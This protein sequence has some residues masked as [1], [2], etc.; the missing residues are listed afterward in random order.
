MKRNT[1]HDPASQNGSPPASRWIWLLIIAC[2]LVIFIALRRAAR[3]HEMVSTEASTDPPRAGVSSGVPNAER[4]RGRPH[5]SSPAPAQ[6]ADEIVASKVK[7]FG[8]SRR[9]VARRI[10]QRLQKDVPVEVE[11]FF[12]AIESGRWEEIKA[13][14]EVLAKRSGQ[15]ADSDPGHSEELNPFWSAVLD[16]YGVAEQAHDWPAQKLLD[17]GNAVLDSLRPGMV[18]VGGTDNG[19]WIPEL[20]N[21]TG[22]G[23]QHVIL[24]QNALADAR[25]MDWMRELYG[26]RLA[27][28]SQEDSQ[29]AFEEYTADAQKRLEHD[30]QFPDEPKQIRPGEEV[31]LVDG[32]VQVSSQVGVMTINEK[33]LQMLMDKNPDLS[34]ALQESF[35]LKGTYG[36]AL[37]LGPLMELRAQDG[38]TT[39]TAERAAQSLDYWR[40]RTQQV[41]SD[42]EAV[43][44]PSA[45]KSYSHDAVSAANLLAA[46]HF[47]DEAEQTYRLGMQLWPENPES[48]GGLADLLAST[49]RENEARQ[50]LD[51]FAR[52]H[53]AQKK[54]LEQTTAWRITSQPQTG[55]P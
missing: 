51:E 30:Q 17:Y 23:E 11:A 21:D 2:A 25:Y 34:F 19:R 43:N 5:R 8:R 28:P 16:A 39:F 31:K 52:Q 6:T 3:H 29:R 38:E 55:K 4:T 50:V 10:A 26:D 47:T 32:R 46:H 37:P 40:D 22:G 54:D 13:R 45:L 12:D 14:W 24:T 33:L 53:P 48:A 15:Y 41:F 1:D 49:G 44:S 20:L 35:P 42:P 7:Q 36:D 18:Y 27:T 9:E